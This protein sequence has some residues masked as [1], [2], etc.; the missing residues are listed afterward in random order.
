MLNPLTGREIH[1]ADIEVR[2]SDA[3]FGRHLGETDAMLITNWQDVTAIIDDIGLTV[4][5][6]ER[7]LCPVG[8]LFVVPQGCG[9]AEVWVVPSEMPYKYL[10]ASPLVLGGERLAL[11]SEPVE[12]A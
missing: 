3:S 6:I 2:L 12:E 11:T 9:F 5:Q 10:S 4:E 7:E 1:A 8:A